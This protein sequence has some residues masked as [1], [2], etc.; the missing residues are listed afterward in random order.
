MKITKF[1]HEGVNK[2]G[3]VKDGGAVG[4]KPSVS[5]GNGCGI[6]TCHCSDGYWM[7]VSLGR[8]KKGNVEGISVRFDNRKEM[9]ECLKVE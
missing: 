5:I 3:I 2:K 9:V 8:D 4:I 1:L 6:N 7:C